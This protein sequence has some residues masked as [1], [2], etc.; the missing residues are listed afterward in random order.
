MRQ[1]GSRPMSERLLPMP[2]G[3][4]MDDIQRFQAKINY[5]AGPEG[6]LPWI[7]STSHG[8]GNFWLKSRN[9]VAARVAYYFHYRIDPGVLLV[10]H[11]CDNPICVNPVHLELGDQSQNML[12]AFSRGRAT[13]KGS[14]SSR[15]IFVE[16]MI[17]DIR[18]RVADGETQV[19]I[20]KS[21]GVS[22][23]AIRD[24]IRGRTWSHIK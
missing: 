6:C 5:S 3:Y 15:A 24:I 12:D 19:S 7:G 2:K 9:Y 14:Q 23:D 18:R 10:C 8:R 11:K 20:A 22:Y 1:P 13:K 16:T 4:G 21:F 17:P